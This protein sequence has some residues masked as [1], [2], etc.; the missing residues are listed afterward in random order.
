M[1]PA[2]KPIRA[3]E[4]MDTDGINSEQ[5]TVF[6]D[7]VDEPNSHDSTF[8]R[9]EVAEAL[10]LLAEVRNIKSDSDSQTG[11]LP[12]KIGRYLSLIHI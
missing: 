7:A 8:A 2:K 5:P 1:E 10:E 6:G 12:E 3:D 11:R 9:N 4:L